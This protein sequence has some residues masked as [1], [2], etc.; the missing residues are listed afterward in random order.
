VAAR[1]T[2]VGLAIAEELVGGQHGGG[3]G[4]WEAR[5]QVDVIV[6][7]DERSSMPESVPVGRECVS[8][9]GE[10]RGGERWHHGGGHLGGR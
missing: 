1:Q 6:A 4:R 8:A 3:L 10:E 9:D 7:E 5:G 2:G